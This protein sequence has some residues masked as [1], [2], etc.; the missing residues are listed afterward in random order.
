MM[1]RNLPN[2]MKSLNPQIQEVQQIKVRDTEKTNNA[3]II[4][5]FKTSHKEN[6]KSNQEKRR[7]ITC[8]R[9]G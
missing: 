8:G 6:I 7:H 2:L 9:T 3:H 1:T 4:K 5:L